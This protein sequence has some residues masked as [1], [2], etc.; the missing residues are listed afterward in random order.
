MAKI[1]DRTLQVTKIRAN[2][3]RS[4]VLK[5]SPN[6]EVLRPKTQINEM[7]KKGPMQNHTLQVG[8]ITQSSWTRQTQQGQYNFT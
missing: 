7:K 4:K 1:I 3:S 2:A 6:L 8:Y 5:Q